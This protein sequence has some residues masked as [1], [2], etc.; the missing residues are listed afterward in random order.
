MRLDHPRRVEPIL[1]HAQR[2]RQRQH[3]LG[4]VQR[5]KLARIEQALRQRAEQIAQRFGISRLLA[6]AEERVPDEEREA[7]V[8]GVDAV[9]APEERPERADD[10]VRRLLV[11][12]GWQRVARWCEIRGVAGPHA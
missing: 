8:G 3:A 5:R 1:G 6:D 9:D 11:E 12:V 4:N 2:P 7:A 10:E